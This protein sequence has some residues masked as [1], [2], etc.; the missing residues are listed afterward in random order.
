M[1]AEP[2]PANEAIIPFTGSGQ[3]INLTWNA[4]A[5]NAISWDVFF[6]RSSPPAQVATGV[7]ANSY[8]TQIQKVALI[9]GR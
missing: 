2:L 4:T 1:P 8:T 6:G 5:T 7:T 9:I 3:T